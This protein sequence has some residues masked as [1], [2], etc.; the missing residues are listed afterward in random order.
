MQ[1][2]LGGELQITSI[3]ELAVVAQF[4]LLVRQSW[5]VSA[6]S[7][8]LEG[9]VV[10]ISHGWRLAEGWG[11]GRVGRVTICLTLEPDHVRGAGIA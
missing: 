11:R 9:V 4:W 3:F 2:C 10:L 7:G 1:V 8:M 6:F 5:E